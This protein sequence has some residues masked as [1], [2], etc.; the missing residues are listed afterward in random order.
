MSMTQKSTSKL[1]P[2]TLIIVFR[3]PIISLRELS[4]PLTQRLEGVSRDLAMPTLSNVRQG[5]IF[6][7]DPLST[8]DMGA[9]FLLKLIEM[10]NA[11]A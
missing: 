8:S 11:F 1:T 9:T 10:Y 5:Q 4:K 2:A 7:T 6:N 3:F